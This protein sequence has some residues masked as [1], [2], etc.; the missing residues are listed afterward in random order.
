MQKNLPVVQ[1][2]FRRTDG[3]VEHTTASTSMKL[4]IVSSIE[5]YLLNALQS[6]GEGVK[7]Q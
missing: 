7:L 5:K 1:N 3:S 4:T 2:F 6:V